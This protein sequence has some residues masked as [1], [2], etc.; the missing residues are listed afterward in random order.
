MEFVGEVDAD[1]PVDGDSLVDEVVVME[2]EEEDVEV[3]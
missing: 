2:E 1:V 3:E